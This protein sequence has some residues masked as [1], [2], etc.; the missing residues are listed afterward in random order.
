MKAKRINTEDSK[1]I[2]QSKCVQMRRATGVLDKSLI[3]YRFSQH[4][5]L[6]YDVF[7]DNVKH[8]NKGLYF[9]LDKNER[10]AV[11]LIRVT[12]LH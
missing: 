1:F 8:I 11:V 9:S 4:C 10:L 7:S 2:S 3:N 12:E 5:I 6:Q